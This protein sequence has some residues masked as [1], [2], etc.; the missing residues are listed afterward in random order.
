MRKRARYSPSQP[1]GGGPRGLGVRSR[2][3]HHPVC[4]THATHCSWPER[5]NRLTASPL[6]VRAWVQT[7]PSRP[8]PGIGTPGPLRPSVRLGCVITAECCPRHF[9][10]AFSVRLGDLTRS[11]IFGHADF[12]T[13]RWG[14]HPALSPARC[15][16][17]PL[18]LPSSRVLSSGRRALRGTSCGPL[19]SGYVFPAGRARAL[20][21]TLP[22]NLPHWPQWWC[23][24]TL[25]S[26]VRRG[27]HRAP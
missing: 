20:A 21:A 16:R 27:V 12:F 1:P 8:P 22:G 7:P 10:H 2:P 14:R 19:R 23:T 18:C 5:G 13:S 15:V 9:P 6:G 17:G 26:G 25:I 3:G 4:G 11:R 24:V